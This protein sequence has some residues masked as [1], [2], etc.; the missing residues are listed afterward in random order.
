MQ[1][2]DSPQHG[3][4]P[5]DSMAA[6]V[7]CRLALCNTNAMY[8]WLLLGYLPPP[9]KLQHPWRRMTAESDIH[10]GERHVDKL[11]VPALSGCML[12]HEF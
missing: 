10:A 8:G 7:C 4:A 5:C 1:A 3:C 6:V 2:P 9:R 11:R 12:S